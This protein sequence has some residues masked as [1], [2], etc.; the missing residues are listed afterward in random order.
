MLHRP[1]R[2]AEALRNRRC[3]KLCSPRACQVNTGPAHKGFLIPLSRHGLMAELT[4]VP[5]RAGRRDLLSQGF[6]FRLA[7][8][9][10]G[11]GHESCRVAAACYNARLLR[12]RARAMTANPPT[13]S[14]EEGG[15]GTATGVT[16][17]KV[18]PRRISSMVQPP[19]LLM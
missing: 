2:A 4:P 18:G 15:A 14:N 11:L 13:I 16:A 3:G 9:A 8:G 1:I 5:R 12:R 6:Q 10:A 7:E 17:A 19:G